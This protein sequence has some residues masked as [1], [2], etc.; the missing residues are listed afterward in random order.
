MFVIEFRISYSRNQTTV[1][2]VHIPMA[3]CRSIAD[4]RAKSP[5][6]SNLSTASAGP[7]PSGIALLPLLRQNLRHDSGQIDCRCTDWIDLL[8]GGCCRLLCKNHTTGWQGWKRNGLLI[9]H[10]DRLDE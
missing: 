9:S 6:E 8:L 7:A 3:P 2:F 4:C 1:R 5:Q 10:A